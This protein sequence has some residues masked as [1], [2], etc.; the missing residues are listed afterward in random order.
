MG[1][2]CGVSTGH[3]VVH[4][5]VVSTAESAHEELKKALEQK[6]C[7]LKMDVATHG[8]RSFLAINA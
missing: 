8:N 1:R 4:H 7:Y 6:L 3:D 2:Q 5:L